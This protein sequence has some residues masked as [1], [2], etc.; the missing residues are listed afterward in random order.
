MILDLPNWAPSIKQVAQRITART[1][2]PNGDLAGTFNSETEP[3]VDQV[4]EIIESAISFLRPRLGEVAESMADQAQALAAL[5]AAYMVE[6]AFF[7]EQAESVTSP[8]RELRMEFREELENWDKAAR[9]E[10]PNDHSHMT[11]L[12][13]GTLYPGYAT[14]TF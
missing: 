14:G 4:T 3:S 8:Y 13:V 11:S 7:P 6:I 1:R 10:E 5:R 9:G 2:M 12:P